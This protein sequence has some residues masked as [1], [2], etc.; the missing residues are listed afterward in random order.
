[1]HFNKALHGIFYD[2]EMGAKS[3][4]SCRKGKDGDLTIALKTK[5][6]NVPYAESYYVKEKF[7][8]S[9]IEGSEDKCTITGFEKSIF[10]GD[11]CMKDML[12]E[13]VCEDKKKEHELWIQHIEQ[14]KLFKKPGQE[15]NQQ[16]LLPAEK[17][18]AKADV[19]E[20]E[21]SAIIN[22]KDIAHGK[23]I[24]EGLNLPL[25]PRPSIERNLSDTKNLEGKTC[26]D[27]VNEKSEKSSIRPQ[28]L[29]ESLEAVPCVQES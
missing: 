26:S 29:A 10:T 4:Q 3:I 2:T 22:P 9:P 25:T 1:M 5:L 28:N 17:E 7:V 6:I 19:V 14:N 11:C 20:D 18:D 8:L 15:Q 23:N 13:R 24:V 12:R 21:E 27:M 16:I